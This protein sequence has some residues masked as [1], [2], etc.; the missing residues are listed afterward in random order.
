MKIKICGHCEQQSKKHRNGTPHE[1]LLKFDEPRV[2]IGN[3][4][5]G[6]TE[7]DYQCLTCTSKFTHSTNKRDLTWTL[8]RG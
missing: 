2:F 8:W 5:K 7:Q 4:P 6:Y 1:H 3:G